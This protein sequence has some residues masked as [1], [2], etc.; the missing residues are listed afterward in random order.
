MT[1]GVSSPNV[2]I[3]SVGSASHGGVLLMKP[4]TNN[5]SHVLLYPLVNWH[6]HGKSG[7]NLNGKSPINGPFPIA[8]L[9]YMRLITDMAWNSH[10]HYHAVHPSLFPKELN[11]GTLMQCCHLRPAAA[12]GN[13]RAFGWKHES[14][15]TEVHKVYIYIYII[16]NIHINMWYIY[17]YI[18]STNIYIY[19][20]IYMYKYLYTY[21]LHIHICCIYIYIFTDT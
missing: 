2:F 5:N 14:H 15:P 17:I 3:Y 4:F 10:S 16:H 13:P 18:I 1:S 19:I 20:Y 8:I 12:S 9:I 11:N 21:I 6:S 7:L